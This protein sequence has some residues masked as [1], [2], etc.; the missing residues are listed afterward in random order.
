MLI[1]ALLV[2]FVNHGRCKAG[3]RQTVSLGNVVNCV[4]RLP[5]KDPSFPASPWFLTHCRSIAGGPHRRQHG[6]FAA[7]SFCSSLC[8]PRGSSVCGICNQR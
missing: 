1:M 8:T 6:Q 5:K 3:Y 2:S 4:F 7:R